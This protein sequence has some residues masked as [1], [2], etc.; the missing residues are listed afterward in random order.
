MQRVRAVL[1]H[2]AALSRFAIAV[3]NRVSLP[4]IQLAAPPAPDNTPLYFP[5]FEDLNGVFRRPICSFDSSGEVEATTVL[6]GPD[7]L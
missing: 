1:S 5:V 6:V 4:M 2:Q 3:P 7:P